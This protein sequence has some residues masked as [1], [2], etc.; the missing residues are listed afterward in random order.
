MSSGRVLRECK[1]C[2]CPAMFA[3][4]CE[5]GSE[6]VIRVP[7]GDPFLTVTVPPW[8]SMIVRLMARPVPFSRVVK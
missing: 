3:L 4:L 6:N 7:K 5:T 2:D 8:V 1:F